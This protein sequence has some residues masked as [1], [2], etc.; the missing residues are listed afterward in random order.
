MACEIRYRPTAL[1]QLDAIYSY[2]ATPDDIAAHRVIASIPSIGL[3]IFPT[4]QGQASCFASNL[5]AIALLCRPRRICAGRIPQPRAGIHGRDA[6]AVTLA[7]KCGGTNMSPVRVTS[8]ACFPGS[9][10]L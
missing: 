1:A 6:A 3:P 10:R 4:A 9:E 7:G 8:D 2:I 5:R